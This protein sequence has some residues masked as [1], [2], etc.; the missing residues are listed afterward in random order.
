[1]TARQRRIPLV[2]IAIVI[3]AGVVFLGVT[4][5]QGGESV[6]VPLPGASWT[7]G[8]I[9]TVLAGE[10]ARRLLKKLDSI[11]EKCE[12]TSGEFRE[13]RKT[14]EIV[15]SDIDGRGGL[16]Q[17]VRDLQSS[18][19]GDRGPAPRGVAAPRDF[20]IAPHNKVGA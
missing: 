1:M 2:G 10:F 17:D 8:G 12:R 15:L 18:V 3:V 6:N 7:V 11:D 13:F 20:S 16:V 14:V 4:A 9:V 5:M 19:Y